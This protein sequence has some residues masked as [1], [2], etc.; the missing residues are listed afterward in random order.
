MI[1]GKDEAANKELRLEGNGKWKR[2]A[3]IIESAF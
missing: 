1:D 3:K 2:G